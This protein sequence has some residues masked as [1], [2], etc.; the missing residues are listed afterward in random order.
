MNLGALFFTV[1]RQDIFEST[2]AQL[3]SK[4]FSGGGGGGG[5]GGGRGGGGVSS[6]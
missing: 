3:F 6:G 2:S 5:G 4:P 1:S